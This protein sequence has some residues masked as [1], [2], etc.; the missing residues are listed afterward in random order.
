MTKT[1]IQ[2]L[3]IHRSPVALLSDICDRYLGINVQTARLKAVK[4]ALPFP[5]F[6]P[7]ADSSRSPWMVKLT[8]LAA[9]LDARG[10]ACAKEWQHSQL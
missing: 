6:R 2:L 10:E 5:V 1:E 8:D 7:E 4:H 3:A 9:F